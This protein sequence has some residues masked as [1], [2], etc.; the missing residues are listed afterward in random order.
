MIKA[1]YENGCV[2]VGN[3][4]KVCWDGKLQATSSGVYWVNG[5]FKS[6]CEY[7]EDR[8]L[9]NLTARKLG[10]MFIVEGPDNFKIQVD[11]YGYWVEV[12]G[13]SFIRYL[14]DNRK[15]IVT[16][17]DIEL[18]ENCFLYEEAVNL[19]FGKWIWK[20]VVAEFD[21]RRI[22]IVGR[23]GKMLE[24]GVNDFDMIDGRCLIYG[25]VEK[26]DVFVEWI[27]EVVRNAEYKGLRRRRGEIEKVILKYGASELRVNKNGELTSVRWQKNGLLVRIHSNVVEI[28]YDEDGKVIDL[29]GVL[30]ESFEEIPKEENKFIRKLIF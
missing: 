13:N 26:A 5:L 19:M 2:V 27:K 21:D 9:T 3:L 22:A 29:V 18:V 10:R 24:I 14:E 11:R 28:K 12:F 20:N 8:L 25:R 15:F 23:D 17:G 4:A 1:R 16:K 6:F 30:R 7:F